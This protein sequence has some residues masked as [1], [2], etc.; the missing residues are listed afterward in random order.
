MMMLESALAVFMIAALT[1]V[2]DQVGWACTTRA[3]TPVVCG[4]AIEVPLRVWA[5]VPLPT[6]AEEIETPGAE[7]SGLRWLSPSRGPPELKSAMFLYVGL[8]MRP[9]GL[10]VA[11]WP[12]AAMSA[13]WAVLSVPI[14]GIVKSLG[15]APMKAGRAP[16]AV[17]SRLTTMMA[18]APAA[19]A[20]WPFWTKG[21]TPRL[22]TTIAPAATPV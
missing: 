9:P 3:A 20:R 2:G 13:A 1:R 19:W 8:A 5:S 6:N 15:D 11:L 4:A 7:T 16:G 22:T 12:S 17:S 10:S 18:E 14:I 21:H